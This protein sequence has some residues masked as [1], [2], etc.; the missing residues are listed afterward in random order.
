MNAQPGSAPGP[1][2]T[3]PAGIKRRQDEFI[4][5][6]N[7]TI[8]KQNTD[9]MISLYYD[10][11]LNREFNPEAFIFEIKAD[12]ENKIIKEIL[13][14]MERPSDNNNSKLLLKFLIL[15][16]SNL[17][18]IMSDIEHFVKDSINKFTP[19]STPCSKKMGNPDKILTAGILHN[20]T[21]DPKIVGKILIKFSN[22]MYILCYNHKKRTS[23]NKPKYDEFLKLY[24]PL[25]FMMM[26]LFIDELPDN[27]DK[28]SIDEL[29]EQ[30]GEE[31]ELDKLAALRK[32]EEEMSL[33]ERLAKLMDGLP[34]DKKKEI[35]EMSIEDK[36]KV[37]L[38]PEEF[39]KYAEERLANL[40]ANNNAAGP[41]SGTSGGSRKLR[42]GKSKRSLRRRRLI[43]KQS[44]GTKKHSKKSSKRRLNK[45]KKSK[46]KK[47]RRMLA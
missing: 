18:T 42:K 2:N 45:N 20:V 37:M 1:L 24:I 23:L 5:E 33:K 26:Q 25:I 22:M 4:R 47:A 11:F 12:K 30:I 15:N 17:G 46:S 31:I 8:K 29:L 43:K 35:Y 27:T 21:K 13:A 36:Q 44:G 39:H 10:F 34:A 9:L 38:N 32:K 3:S 14:L 16:V 6:I 40:K 28:R 19:G 7:D 41:A